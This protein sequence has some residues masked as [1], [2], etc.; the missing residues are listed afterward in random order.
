MK[1]VPILRGVA[2]GAPM[3]LAA[4]SMSPA[5]PGSSG[6]ETP[7]R[8]EKVDYRCADGA[9]MSV[10]YMANRTDGGAEMHWDGHTF[11]LQQETTG[12]GARYTDGTLT[13][14]AKG[15]EAFVQKGGETVL[16]DC[17]AKT[18]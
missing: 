8:F 1:N 13:L 14:F 9:V 6:G 15:D 4:C 5:T 10:T 7:P 3:L 16:R 11:P 12:S 2:A 18:P 17:N